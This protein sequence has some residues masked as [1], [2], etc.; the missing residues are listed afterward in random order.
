MKPYTFT[1]FAVIL[2][3]GLSACGPSRAELDATATQVAAEK[4][5]SQTAA[6]PTATLTPTNTTTPTNTATPTSTPD[7]TAT[8]IVEAT[9]TTEALIGRIEQELER[10]GLSADV[11]RLG[12]YSEEAITVINDS[13]NEQGTSQ[14][15]ADHQ[16]YSDFVLHTNLIGKGEYGCAIILRWE[17]P[18]ERGLQYRFFITN[19]RI[20]Y[21]NRSTNFGIEKYEYGGILRIF[22]FF[23]TSQSYFS[24]P[25]EYMPSRYSSAINTGEE[26]SNEIV[27]I[28]NH[29]TLTV[30]ANG[31][32]MDDF[33]IA[34]RR[35]G[36]LGV[37]T[38]SSSSACTFEDTWVW[39]LSEQGEED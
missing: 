20:F 26:P 3:V 10:Y 31:E 32:R 11:G 8:A 33:N 7:L 29:F 34:S 18:E 6:A 12:W 5:A 1:I 4:S 38:Y 14:G 28:A 22:Y 36:Y 16:S 19:D 37:H 17:K 15:I 23:G 25:S 27:L 9:Q 24:V 2:L 30:Y 21:I 13:D 35:E 39:D